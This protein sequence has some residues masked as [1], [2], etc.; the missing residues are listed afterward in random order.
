MSSTS[1]PHL[2]EIYL[3]GNE[4]ESVEGIHRICMPNIERVGMGRNRLVFLKEL[5]KALW[6]QIKGVWLCNY[7]NMQMVTTCL[8]S[9]LTKCNL[10]VWRKLACIEKMVSAMT[11]VGWPNSNSRNS[12]CWVG[13]DGCRTIKGKHYQARESGSKT[14]GQILQHKNELIR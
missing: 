12:I 6:R 7:P 9:R 4:I 13:V 1:F 8:S 2:R 10:A 3:S 11:C 14:E 5:R